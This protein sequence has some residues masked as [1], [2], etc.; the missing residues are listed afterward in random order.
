[1]LVKAGARNYLATK[2][3]VANV[4]VRHVLDASTTATKVLW[5]CSTSQ[6]QDLSGGNM[7]FVP[8]P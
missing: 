6:L 3:L 7:S 1:M 8:T 5:S 4:P 2:Q